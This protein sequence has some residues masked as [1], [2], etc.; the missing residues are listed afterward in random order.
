MNDNHRHV[1]QRL[2]E[3]LEDRVLFDAVPDGGF[4][5]QPEST[6][7]DLQVPQEQNLQTTAVVEETGPRQLIIVDSSVENADQLLSDILS[8]NAGTSFEVRLLN[9]VEDGVEQISQILAEGGSNTYSAI[10]LVSHG[11]ASELR[12]GSTLLNTDTLNSYAGELAM[13]ADSLTV[14]AD[15]LLYGCSVGDGVEGAAFVESLAT[16]TGADIAASS[17]L[18]G[19]TDLGGDWVFEVTTGLIETSGFVSD[20][21]AAGWFSVLANFTSGPLV[22]VDFGPGTDTTSPTNWRHVTSTGTFSSLLNENGVNSGISINV[23]TTGSLSSIDTNPTTSTLPQHGQSLTGLDGTL[24]DNSGGS[25]QIRL[26]WSGLTA[27]Q[28]YAIYTFAHYNSNSLQTI[29]V[30]GGNGT[31]VLGNQVF[32][33][34]SMT[35]N[36]MTGSSTMELEDFATIVTA[37][38]SGQITVT[39]TSDYWAVVSGAAIAAVSNVPPTAIA[40]VGV[41]VEDAAPNPITGNVISNDSTVSGALTVSTVNGSAGNVGVAVNGAYGTFQLNADGSYTYTLNNSL[42]AVQQ[43]HHQDNIVYV[44]TH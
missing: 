37:N 18:T 17:N 36:G 44:G 40:D 14:D 32:A 6:T 8:G 41:V 7:T 9:P 31:T 20:E 35:I 23:S 16:L 38:S 10:H 28:E 13:W 34:N 2:R 1:S 5:T 33:A 11:A 22:G 15:I 4:L 25:E 26:V 29:T 24:V 3:K 39:V 19:H 43:L 42:A 30:D 21:V 12:L 27:G